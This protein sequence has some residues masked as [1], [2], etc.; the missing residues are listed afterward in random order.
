MYFLTAVS[1]KRANYIPTLLLLPL[2]SFGCSR[3]LG[4]ASKDADASF[5]ERAA[6]GGI[7]EVRLG[8]LA[9][10][11]GNSVAVKLFGSQMVA[12]HTQ[13]GNK[14]Q[15]AARQANLSILPEMSAEDRAIYTRLSSL[16]GSAFDQAYATAMVND[17][18]A[19]VT[20]FEKE[21]SEGKVGD[22]R[23]FAADTLPTL[24]DH[25]DKARQL[26]KNIL[27]ATKL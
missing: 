22:M 9:Q 15:I 24:K 1:S 25:L 3:R 8:Q 6:A 7:A 18:E 17:H 12:D 20:E 4:T 5:A 14:L 27:S 13:A 21:A 2:L 19:A 16:S 26:Q 11:R 23:Q 10:D